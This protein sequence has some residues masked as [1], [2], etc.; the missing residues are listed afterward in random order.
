M[1]KSRSI[2]LVTEFPKSNLQSERRKL[3]SISLNLTIYIY[4]LELDPC[5]CV[6]FYD[7]LFYKLFSDISKNIVFCSLKIL[8]HQNRTHPDPERTDS[9]PTQNFILPERSIIKKKL[10]TKKNLF[11]SERIPKYT[12]ITD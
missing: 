3:T 9:N 12:Y 6:G 5:G 4:K 8:I 1:S 10:N 2:K 7:F 11:L